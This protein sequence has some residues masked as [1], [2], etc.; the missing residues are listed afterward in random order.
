MAFLS[1][2]PV[3]SLRPLVLTSLLPVV[4]LA[5][6]GAD[7]PRYGGEPVVLMVQENWK[8]EVEEPTDGFFDTVDRNAEDLAKKGGVG[9][10]V[11]GCVAGGLVVAYYV[12]DATGSSGLIGC[13]AGGIAL[14]PVGYVAG[15][16][17][18]AVAGTVQGA[19]NALSAPGDEVDMPALVEAVEGATPRGDL[20]KAVLERAR[21]RSDLPIAWTAE[22]GGLGAASA[23]G[24]QD[25]VFELSLTI[26]RLRLATDTG[27]PPESQLRIAVVGRLRD[28]ATGQ[29]V[30]DGDW[31]YV[32][33]RRAT[34]ELAADG[35]RALK[36]ELATGWSTLAEEIL[37]DLFEPDD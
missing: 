8:L 23:N 16:G 33:E 2:V 15:Y 4:T 3:R 17:T 29:T 20:A 14:F 22:T 5:C 11:V 18:G 28:I 37:T 7:V 32:S 12:P 30:D 27:V 9:T 1:F 31:C 6:A 13:V 34:A 36:A 24:G 21:E 19:I 10:A 26:T 25:P 35:A